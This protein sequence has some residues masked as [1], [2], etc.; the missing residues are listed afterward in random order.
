MCCINLKSVVSTPPDS[1]LR[2]N[3][4]ALTVRTTPVQ[5]RYEFVTFPKQGVPIT[6]ASVNQSPLQTRQLIA[7]PS[8]IHARIRGTA[9]TSGVK[10][11]EGV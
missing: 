6:N 2:A 4:R 5:W 7:K 10:L 9:N 3:K 11:R 8:Q 1:R